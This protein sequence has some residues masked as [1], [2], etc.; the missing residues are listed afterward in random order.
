MKGGVWLYITS[1]WEVWDYTQWRVV[2]DFT[3]HH[4]EKCEAI[5]NEGWC[6]T[7][8]HIT[9]RSVR[10]YSMKGGVWLYI[11][12]QWEVWDYTQWRVVCYFT[13]HHNEK[14]ETILNEG[15]C[16][17][18]H[19]ITMR[20]VRLHSMKG[21]VLL[22]ITSQWEVWD[23]I[24]W[25]VVCYFTSH[26]NEKCETILNKRWC[27]TLHH[28]TMRSVRLHSMKGG[29][30][31]YI[32]SQW[33]V[34]DYI[35]WRVVCYFTSHHNEE[36]ETILNEGWCVTL[37]HIT[38]R[39]VRL[40]SMKGGVLL[41]ITSQWEVWDYTQWRVVC[42][43][44]SH[45]SEKCETTFNEGWWVTLHHIT[46]RRVRLYS[47][48]GGVLLYITSQWGVERCGLG[49]W[50]CKTHCN[51]CM[52][53]TW[54]SFWGKAG[55]GNLVF[56]RVKWLRPAMNTSCV[57]RVRLRSNR[58]GLVPPLCS[59]M[60]GFSCVRSFMRFLTLWLQIAV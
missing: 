11:T 54:A 10:L 31:P 47:M 23:Y 36:C 30:L 48:K 20:S 7:L 40:H 9:M 25:K 16:V 18:L 42:Y 15:W 37:H 14:C 56:F 28:I 12:S 6:V 17:T 22:Y 33:E 53:V 43:F 46:M 26:Y 50:S 58:S 49:T 27:V 29:V 4:N 1:Q 13:S 44:T 45:H 51:G 41:Y 3:S 32:T 35:Q 34:W 39:S 60:S 55:A 52:D 2:C 59:A 38:M 24:Q 19:H 21:G 57:R 5:L 8:H